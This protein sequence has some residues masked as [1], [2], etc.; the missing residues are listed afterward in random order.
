[1]QL[2]FSFFKAHSQNCEIYAPKLSIFKLVCS[3]LGLLLFPYLL[4]T[5]VMPHRP[6]A[7]V[8][9]DSCEEPFYCLAT[10]HT[11]L[12]EVGGESGDSL[13][14]RLTRFLGGWPIRSCAISVV[15]LQSAFWMAS[16]SVQMDGCI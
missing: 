8:V 5:L 1:M 2:F 4:V 9:C 10:S 14:S 11:I 15:T 16:I 7:D 13:Y 6:P 12:A 3:G